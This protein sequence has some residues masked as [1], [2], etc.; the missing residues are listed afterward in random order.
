MA[1]PTDMIEGN[2]LV[3]LELIVQQ[4]SRQI[5]FVSLTTCHINFD[6]EPAT[7]L[8]RLANRVRYA[9]KAHSFITRGTVSILNISGRSGQKTVNFPSKAWLEKYLPDHHA[10]V[11]AYASLLDKMGLDIDVSTGHNGGCLDLKTVLARLDELV[12]CARSLAEAPS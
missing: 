9:A 3:T 1:G 8:R 11:E 5:S 4:L 7:V 2:K 12:S 10:R 6:N